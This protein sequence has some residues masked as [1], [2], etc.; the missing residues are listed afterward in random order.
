MANM[1]SSS[2][3][4]PAS[5]SKTNG[6]RGQFFQKWTGILRT[7]P[8]MPSLFTTSSANVL[9]AEESVHGEAGNVKLARLRSNVKTACRVT[10]KE[11]GRCVNPEGRRCEVER[12]PLFSKEEVW[13]WGIPT[14]QALLM[15]SFTCCSS[16]MLILFAVSFPQLL[17]NRE[18]NMLRNKC[19][20]V[21][22]TRYD[23]LVKGGGGGGENDAK[24]L[25]EACG[26]A[27]LPI[28]ENIAQVDWSLW[29][30]AGTCQEYT[31]YTN[32]TQF[33]PF[34]IT[35]NY[36]FVALPS[37]RFCAYTDVFEVSHWLSLI[38]ATLTIIGLLLWMRRGQRLLRMAKSRGIH[39]AADFAVLLGG[40]PRGRFNYIES[41]LLGELLQ[42]GFKEADVVS[43]VVARDCSRELRVLQ[44]LQN[45]CLNL[46]EAR[47][48][49]SQNEVDKPTR[50][51]SST[52][53]LCEKRAQARKELQALG[54]EEHTTTGHAIISFESTSCR[55]RF[56]ERY[57]RP[58][59]S[60]RVL[61]KMTTAWPVDTAQIGGAKDR[62][63]WKRGSTSN[64]PPAA[65]DREQVP[66]L[67]TCT[68]QAAPEP[69]AIL[70]EHLETPVSHFRSRTRVSYVV[71]LLLVLV[72]VV[73][74]GSITL[75]QNHWELDVGL[76]S[77]L[78]ALIGVGMTLINY[79]T[80]VLLRP[81]TAK[82][83]HP[84]K[85]SLELSVF[86]KLAF[87]FMCNS[88]LVP[89]VE[90]SFPFFL[91]QAFYETGG[92]AS[93]V[94][95]AVIFDAAGYTLRV[96]QIPPLFQRYVLAPLTARSQAK[97]DKCYA[98]S[99]HFIGE[100]HAHLLKTFAVPLVCK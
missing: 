15:R 44:R 47:T 48:R 80:K 68:A 76:N 49:N 51:S 5:A 46:D 94:L 27:D 84:T 4:V 20:R 78:S 2:S 77:Y 13:E 91:T 93:A 23:T 26:Y 69:D 95:Y 16:A 52:E 53:A 25:V 72:N 21:L 41:S 45:L 31:S 100:L 37:S 7:R 66:L 9:E 73:I 75:W 89:L 57:H 34:Q 38:G 6:A 18:R 71:M 98:P 56:L 35:R 97:L 8:Q 83:R 19:R 42:A 81:L 24:G 74:I 88:V 1:E 12:M 92:L 17:D 85:T 10:F 30:A 63:K 90:Y 62:L 50:A 32:S 82:E 65:V 60:T 64:S 70:W 29:Y 43:I 99:P 11:N 22:S 40:L 87:A 67:T 39:S 33:S 14:A 58:R 28:R 79:V 55:A 36:P 54:N 86:N 3:S 96:F 61:S 59:W